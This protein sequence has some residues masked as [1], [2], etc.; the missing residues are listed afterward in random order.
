MVLMALPAIFIKES[1]FATVVGEGE[2]KYGII[3]SIKQT[4][5]VKEFRK[6][7]FGMTF[8]DISVGIP[9][10]ALMYIVSLLLRLSG[11][12]STVLMLIIMVGQVAF[13]PVIYALMKKRQKKS[14]M[15]VGIC[16]CAAAYILLYFYQPL[17]A[18]FG[19]GIV[20]GGSPL[21]MIA[22]EG[23]MVGNI[24][25]L[26][27]V[28]LCFTYPNAASVTVGASMFAD[29]ALY[30]RVKTGRSSSGMFMAILNL[31]TVIK[32][33]ITPAVTGLMIYLG[34]TDQNP[35]A[36]GVQSAMIISMVLIVPTF[37]FYNSMNSKEIASVIATI[38]SASEAE[39]VE[40]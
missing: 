6:L 3:E 39:P 2:R 9:T 8:Y 33:S 31:T 29:I 28:G 5:S 7:I 19:T 13:F 30:D 11:V 23:A 15:L 17:G 10:A 12:M 4:L 1:D 20:A 22:G 21:A 24:V 16:C 14:L 25:I 40:A 32:Q 26:V 34:S 38:G 18:L 37:F 35:T 27:L 36:F